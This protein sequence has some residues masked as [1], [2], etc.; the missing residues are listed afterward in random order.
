MRGGERPSDSVHS[1]AGCVRPT[2]S[3]VRSGA[4]PSSRTCTAAAKRFRAAKESYR[5]SFRACMHGYHMLATQLC[6]A[7]AGVSN[8]A[9]Q[10][11]YTQHAR[12]YSRTAAVATHCRLCDRGSKSGVLVL[13]VHRTA[14]VYWQLR[15]SSRKRQGRQGK[16]AVAMMCGGGA[17][18]AGGGRPHRAAEAD[19]A[20]LR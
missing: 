18:S 14:C 1:V 17:R 2:D 12:C 10:C 7:G 4:R 5:Y 6:E 13:C 9:L 8:S 11:T 3:E 15:A 20:R 19:F 16:G